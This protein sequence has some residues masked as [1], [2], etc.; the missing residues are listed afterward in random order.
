MPCT[1]FINLFTKLRRVCVKLRQFYSVMCFIFLWA[2]LSGLY[3]TAIVTGR[4]SA[5]ITKSPRHIVR[6]CR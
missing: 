3:V 4:A 5:W 2:S 6:I 1:E